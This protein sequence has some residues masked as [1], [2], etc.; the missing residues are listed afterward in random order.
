MPKGVTRLGSMRAG[1]VSTS[2]R[3]FTISSV[4][5][6]STWNGTI[7]VA[8][9][10]RKAIER[11]GKRMRANAYPARLHSTRLVAT[12]VTETIVLLTSHRPIGES[13]QAVTKLCQCSAAG[14]PGGKRRVSARDDTPVTSIQRSGGG[15]KQAGGVHKGGRDKDEVP[16][17][18][19]APTA[20]GPAG[21]GPF[22]G[23]HRCAPDCEGS[24]PKRS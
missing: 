20:S 7:S 18:R 19:A 2:P 23:R 10:A 17:G 21:A 24:R 14:S 4:G 9:I 6:I 5:I 3:C 22:E 15:I 11:P 13:V 1:R 8:R 16:A 12:Q